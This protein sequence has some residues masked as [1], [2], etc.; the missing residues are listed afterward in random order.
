MW[1]VLSGDFDSNITKDKCLENVILYAKPGSIVVFHD[2][3]KAFPHLE[4]TLPQVLQSFL[5]KGYSFESLRSEI[6]KI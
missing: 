2:S 3:E 6:I 4:Y 5:K 1:S